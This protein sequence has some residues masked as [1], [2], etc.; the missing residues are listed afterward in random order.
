MSDGTFASAKRIMDWY[1][2]KLAEEETQEA[3]YAMQYA[4]L[5]SLRHRTKALK[6]GLEAYPVEVE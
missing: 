1:V 6:D 5:H 4:A 3:Q 2:A